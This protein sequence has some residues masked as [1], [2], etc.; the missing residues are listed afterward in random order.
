[1][2]RLFRG[3]LGGAAFGLALFAL[4]G[5]LV[6]GTGAIGLDLDTK[7]PFPALFA[8]VRPA[9]PG[10][11]ARVLLAYLLGGAALG[12]FAAWLAALASDVKGLRLALLFTGEWLVIATCLVW[13]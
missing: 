11:L 3:A 10:L 5:A 12:V 7:G 13:I 9:L 1:M 4:E 6:L 8:A 2:K